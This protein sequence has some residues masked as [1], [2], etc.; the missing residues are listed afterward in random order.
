MVVGLN[1]D[2]VNVYLFDLF[3]FG[4]AFAFWRLTGLLSLLLSSWLFTRFF[5][6]FVLFCLGFV[7]FACCGLVWFG[8]EFSFCCFVFVCIRFLLLLLLS[9]FYIICQNLLEIT[10]A[11]CYT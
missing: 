5:F 3:W 2:L 8:F 4:F 1:P 11:V 6:L 7:C 9:W 10:I